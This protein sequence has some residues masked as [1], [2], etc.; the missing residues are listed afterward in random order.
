MAELFSLL[1]WAAAGFLAV[2]WYRAVRE[3]PETEDKEVWHA[4]GEYSD[5][6]TKTTSTG[7]KQEVQFAVLYQIS[8]D[9]KRQCKYNVASSEVALFTRDTSIGAATAL[10]LEGGMFPKEAK[11]YENDTAYELLQRMIHE[12]I[13][14]PQNEKVG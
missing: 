1:P 5:T 2:G 7:A 8:S 13:M 10:W 6:F 4:I 12:R 14:E 11:L 3:K 9:M